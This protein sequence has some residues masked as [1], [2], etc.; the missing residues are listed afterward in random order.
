[1]NLKDIIGSPLYISILLYI[2][3]VIIIVYT[4]PRMFFHED[5]KMKETGCGINKVIFSFPMF[6]VISS[7]LIYFI[8]KIMKTKLRN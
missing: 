5:G 1:M 6:I 8:I 7:I 4:K 2:L 3:I